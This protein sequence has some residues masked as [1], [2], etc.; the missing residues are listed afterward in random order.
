[1]HKSV[2]LTEAVDALHIKKHAKYIDATLGAGGHALEIINRGGEVLG[3]DADPKMLEVARLRLK[4]TPRQARFTL[5]KGNFRDIASI[6]KENS[7]TPVSGIIFDLGVASPHFDEDSRGF[8]F[9]DSDSPLDMRLSDTLGVTAADLLNSLPERNLRELFMTSM[10]YG[11]ANSLAKKVAKYREEKRFEKVSD[12]LAITGEKKFGKIHPAT[13]AF[14]A[15]RIAV[16]SE[17]ENLEEALRG[18]FELIEA[19]GRIAVISFHSGED[20]IVKRYFKTQKEEGK[21]T[22]E[23]LVIPTEKEISENTRARSAKLRVLQKLN[24]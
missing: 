24:T 9:K 7:F 20:K 13:T 3:I 1:M 14:Q 12:L 21:A 22:L 17:Y 15:L 8:S 4:A 18:A 23:D 5:T 6:A 11:K 19:G 10:D 16:N 2:L